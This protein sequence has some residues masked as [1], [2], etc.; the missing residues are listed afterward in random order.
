MKP[1]TRD[2]MQNMIC[3]IREVIPLELSPDDLC[4]GECKV[5]ALKLIE[6]LDMQLEDWQQRI[7]DQ[8]TPDFRDLSRLE[9]TSRKIHAAL[10]KNGLIEEIK[11]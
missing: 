6:Y 7:N 1:N 5:C 9:R 8:Q 11:Q 4:D 10:V 3:E 2:A